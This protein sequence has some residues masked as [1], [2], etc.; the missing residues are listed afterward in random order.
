MNKSSS[1][2]YIFTHYSFLIIHSPQSPKG[3]TQLGE[4]LRQKDHTAAPLLESA[5]LE[6]KSE[7]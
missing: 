4:T 3:Q 5:F 6:V 1:T 2:L 7:K